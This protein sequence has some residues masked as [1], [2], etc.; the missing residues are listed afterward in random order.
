MAQP[1]F[2]DALYT[3]L[4]GIT[5]LT[6]ITTQIASFQ[7]LEGWDRP[8]VVFEEVSSVTP[9]IV[10]SDMIDSL[11][12]IHAFA[13]LPETSGAVVGCKNIMDAIYDGLHESDLTIAGWT[14]YWLAHEGRQQL[15]VNDGNTT[16][17]HYVGDYRIKADN[18]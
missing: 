4:S 8:Y 9:N 17:W 7:A 12:R 11:Y 14:V 2:D 5:A 10:A 1:D 3:K 18:Q 13:D 15:V 6:D 16:Y